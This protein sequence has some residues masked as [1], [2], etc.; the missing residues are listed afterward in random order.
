MN[1]KSV[2]YL[3]LYENIQESYELPHF[4][5]HTVTENIQTSIPLTIYTSWH[6]RSV[7][8]DMYHTVMNNIKMHP[9]FD[10]YIFNEHECR[11]FITTHFT[12]DVLDT[13]DKLKPHAY[14]S[15]LWR[16]CVMYECGGIYMDIKF[17]ID[18]SLK[19][20]IRNKTNVYVK[21][22]LF[23]THG[24][25]LNGLIIQ[26]PKNPVMKSCIDEIVINVNNNYYGEVCLD[27][28]GP[29]LVGKV[30]KQYDSPFICYIN[31]HN[32]IMTYYNT[33]RVEQSNNTNLPHYCELW[34]N[35]NIYNS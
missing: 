22:L 18:T 24:Y 5:E 17:A 14:K 23:D 11:E 4:I 31:N 32:H 20:I 30:V 27:P 6:T 28:T 33:Y 8:K 35:K 26:A 12:K 10:Y 16:Y 21:D 25:V 3:E 9:E 19:D 7:P 1:Y 15:D 34:E 13:Y 2:I 29:G